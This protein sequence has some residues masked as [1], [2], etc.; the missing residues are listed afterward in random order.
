M[1]NGDGEQRMTLEGLQH[2]LQSLRE[3]LIQADADIVNLLLARIAAW[4]L[5]QETPDELDDMLERVLGH[6]WFSSD[7]LHFQVYE[8]VLLFRSKI[9]GFGGMTMNERLVIFD[10]MERWDRSSE[11]ERDALYAKLLARR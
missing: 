5:S 1:Q 2:A 3:N 11:H 8:L 6:S 7:R 9:T 10:L 4:K